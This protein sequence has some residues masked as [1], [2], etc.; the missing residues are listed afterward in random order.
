MRWEYCPDPES[1]RWEKL[2]VRDGTEGLTERGIVSIN[3]PDATT[4][5]ER[6]GT[7][8][9]W[10]RVRVT[11]DAF[12]RGPTGPAFRKEGER[13][14][15][16]K[17]EDRS[18]VADLPRPPTLEGVHPTRSGPTTSGRSAT[19]YWAPATA[20]TTRRSPVRARR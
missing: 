15:E 17:R 18:A 9:H 14:I 12:Y 6:F 16:H 11:G 19:R 13:T 5:F 20:R 3:F 1:G 8:A 4:A 2:E 10:I 7:H